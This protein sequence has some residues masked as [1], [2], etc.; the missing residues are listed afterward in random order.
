MDTL[1][2]PKLLAQRRWELLLP[3]AQSS[4][5][6][7]NGLNTKHPTMLGVVGQQCCVCC[8]GLNINIV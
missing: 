1:Q 8:T 5:K 6:L 7:A 4:K 3:F 2:L